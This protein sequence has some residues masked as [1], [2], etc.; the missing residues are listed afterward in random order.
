MF[1]ILNAISSKLMAHEPNNGLLSC[2]KK[3]LT[4]KCHELAKTSSY[5]E[6]YT[7]SSCL[8]NPR[9]K[10]TQIPKLVIL[11]LFYY[12]KGCLNTRLVICNII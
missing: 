10:C 3:I 12:Y 5:K 8:A 2:N 11:V 4:P 9:M 1:Q 7:K 6:T